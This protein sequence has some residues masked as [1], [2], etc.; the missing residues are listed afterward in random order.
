MLDIEKVDDQYI[1]GKNDLFAVVIMLK[2]LLTE[3]EF[4]EFISELGYE[5][6]IL[7]G[8][9]NVVPLNLILNEI[10]FPNNWRDINKV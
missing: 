2:D 10:G 6:D 5:I 7:D 9:I 8:K 3:K 1:Y 4:I